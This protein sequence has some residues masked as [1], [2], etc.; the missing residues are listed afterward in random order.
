MSADFLA[1]EMTSYTIGAV[2]AVGLTSCLQFSH[3][4]WAS[5]MDVQSV[6][7]TDVEVHGAVWSNRIY[8]QHSANGY[9]NAPHKMASWINQN[10]GV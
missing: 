2:T 9:V 6:R 8:V 10:L 3:D 1:F 7:F 4:Y 5:K